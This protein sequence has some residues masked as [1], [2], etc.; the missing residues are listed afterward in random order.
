MPPPLT[1]V[2]AGTVLQTAVMKAL[3]TTDFSAVRIDWPTDGQPDWP[4]DFDVCFIGIITSNEEYANIERDV[5]MSNLDSKTIQV[6]MTYTRGWRVDLIFY[7]PNATDNARIFHSS[8]FGDAVHDILASSNLYWIPE[9]DTPIRTP[10]E[11]QGQ[12]WERS[13]FSARFYEAVTELSTVPSVAS[14]EVII[15]TAKGVSAD[16]TV[17]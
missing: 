11:F 15:E 3:N 7:G 10:E 1:Q 16:F 13:T 2:T 4:V 9:S 6:T 8:L 17:T 14:I 12:W 5:E